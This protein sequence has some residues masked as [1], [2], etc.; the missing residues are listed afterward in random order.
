MR[1]GEFTDKWKYIRNNP[2]K[3]DLVKTSEAYPALWITCS[4][5]GWMPPAMARPLK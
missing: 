3:A 1:P 2:V 5:D 4:D